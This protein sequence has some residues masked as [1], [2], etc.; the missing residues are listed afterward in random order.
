MN[1]NSDEIKKYYDDL[2]ENISR[3]REGLNRPLTFTEKVF[4]NHLHERNK[5]VSFIRGID[6]AEFSPGRVAMQ[7]ATAQMAMLQ[8]MM[9][10][11]INTSVPSSIHCDHLITAFRGVES[12]LVKALDTNSEVYDFLRS[13]SMAYDIDFWEPGSGII[14]QIILENYAFPGGLMVGTDSHTPNAGGMGMIAVGVGGA[15]AVDVMAGL[16]WELKFPKIIGINLTGKLSG[17]V[18]PKDVIL[19]ITGMLSVRGG[20]GSVLEYFGEGAESISATGKATICNMG[21]ETGATCSV[22]G[23]DRAMADYLIATGRK[24]IA[25]MATAVETHLVSDPEVYD[26]PRKYYDNY[27]EINLSELEPYINGPFTPDL[28]TPISQM[29][30]VA[31]K[32]KW[33]VKI[34]AGLIGSCTNSSYEDISRAASVVKSALREKLT[35]KSD[36]KVTPGSEM[37][38]EITERD[39]LLSLFR[40]IGAD[41]YANACGPCIGQWNRPG[42]EDNPVNTV[43]HSFNRNFAKRNDGNPNTHAF[44]ASPEIV[45]ALTIAGLLTF[46]P[47]TDSLI[48]SEG[49]PVNLPE[50]R[51]LSFPSD[52]FSIHQGKKESGRKKKKPTS[53]TINPRSERLQA[54]TPFK[55]WDGKDLTGLLLLIKASG[56]CTTDHISMAGKWLKYRGHLE[57]ISNNYMIGATNAFNDKTD[58]ILNRLNGTYEPVPSVAFAYKRKG[59]GSIVVGEENF[60]EGSSRE[61]AAMEP[62]FLNV[63]AIIVKSFARIHESNLKKQGIL[64]LTFSDKNDYDKIRETDKIDITGLQDFA[65]GKPVTL[66]LHHDDGTRNTIFANHSYNESQFEWF[67]AGSAINLIRRQRDDRMKN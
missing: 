32:N 62:R 57:N 45:T 52:G 60:G 13:V 51:G 2:P 33:P 16:P 1:F 8:F 41:I 10:G 35:A 9:T 21:A 25:E 53:V 12:D 7:D 26:D 29:K 24:D 56:K 49:R 30:E 34:S 67:R 18:S 43:I 54:L 50:P 47:L 5:I 19:K 39:G 38:R 23:F 28:A 63:R 6:Y 31:E 64:T 65:P 66:I 20:T 4:Y 44:V 27:L 15:D 22:F 48:N 36:L 46:N 59:L 55:A 40:E 61:H 17:W 58:C 42:Q 37:I 14:H 3:I 11:R